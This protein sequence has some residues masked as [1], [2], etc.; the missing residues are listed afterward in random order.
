MFTSDTLQLLRKVYPSRPPLCTWVFGR[1]KLEAL[2]EQMRRLSLTCMP[3]IARTGHGAPIDLLLR[4]DWVWR[5]ASWGTFSCS[6]SRYEDVC[7]ADIEQA[8]KLMHDIEKMSTSLL[9]EPEKCYLLH[10]LFSHVI[11]YRPVTYFQE[12]PSV[13]IPLP[14]RQGNSVRIKS[15]RFD[16]EIDLFGGVLARIFVPCD[17]KG[18]ASYLF[19]GTSPWLC[20]D[21]AGVGLLDDFNPIGPGEFLRSRLKQRLTSLLSD[22]SKKFGEPPL[23]VG[24]SLGGILATAVAVDF[25]HLVGQAIA[26]NPCRPSHSVSKAWQS[27]NSEGSG[28]KPLIDTFVSSFA[29]QGDFVTWVGT[30]W[31]GRVYHVKSAKETDFLG[32][33]VLHAGMGE[34]RD[35]FMH[36][37]DITSDNEFFMRR[38][39]LLAGI[40]SMVVLPAAITLFALLLIKR[41]LVGWNRGG[42]WR[43]GVFGLPFS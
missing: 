31:V 26:F 16:Q 2:H 12:N 41:A 22:H 17:G 39:G 11:A 37:M 34:H 7:L 32:R 42:A 1:N 13:T 15:C 10:S 40:H 24:H 25:P 36:Q 21:G 4:N 33:H 19:P 38:T 6:Y 29:G 5:V 23:V 14:V 18:S 35:A 27:I 8:V 20:A 30:R 28:P 43:W 9:S 3:M